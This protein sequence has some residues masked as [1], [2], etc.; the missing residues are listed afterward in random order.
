MS[1]RPFVLLSQ[2]TLFDPSRAPA[3]KHV[4]WRYCHVPNGWSGS[5]LEA[6]ESQVERFAPGFRDCV[7]GRAVFGTEAMHQWNANLV[8]G[9]INGGSVSGWQFFLRPTWR[10]YATPMKGVYLCSS[11]TPPGGG[12]HGMCGYWGGATSVKAGPLNPIE[13]FKHGEVIVRRCAMHESLDL[14]QHASMPGETSRAAFSL[15]SPKNSPSALSASVT[16][17][18]AS[19]TR[20]PGF[21]C[22]RSEQ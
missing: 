13:H 2:P 16:P 6:I 3:G 17:S 21:S 14:A 8:G 20:S 19:T 11:S 5:A 12:V 7:L 9:D 1:G 4:A 18:V 15:S 10:Q 22:R